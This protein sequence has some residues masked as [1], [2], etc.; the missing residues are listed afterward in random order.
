[1]NYSSQRIV[2]LFILFF[3]NFKTAIFAQSPKKNPTEIKAKPAAAPKK[4]LPD[5]DHFA[6]LM[7]QNDMLVLHQKTDRYF[8]SGIDLQYHWRDNESRWLR[9]FPTIDDKNN[10]LGIKIYSDVYTPSNILDPLPQNDRPYAGV[11]LASLQNISTQIEKRIRMS[12]EYAIGAMGPITKQQEL[13]TLWHKIIKRPA[14]MGWGRQIKN[15]VL[16]EGFFQVEKQLFSVENR[17]EL[18]GNVNADVGTLGNNFGGGATF[19][20]GWLDQY[21]EH[22]FKINDVLNHKKLHVY[23]FFKPNVRLVIDNSLL[24]GGIIN[25]ESS[26]VTVSKDDLKRL[27]FDAQYGYSLA[28]SRFALTYSQQ[29]RTAEF[30]NAKTMFWGNLNLTMGF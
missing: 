17:I 3:C 27:Y 9:F 6:S 28:I 16:I 29:F 5:L 7:L 26:P 19:R 13:Q 15:D 2:F 1:M 20:I 21:F 11:I 12:S 30:R 25:G 10:F 4:L 8:S 14:P 22:P 24:Q 18:I 23:L